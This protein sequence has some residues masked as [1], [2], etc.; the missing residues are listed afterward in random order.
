MEFIREKILGFLRILVWYFDYL[1]YL[2]FNPFKFR[3]L[4]KNIKKILVIELKYI[5]DAI[6]ITP[7]I[8]AL[9]ETY[10]GSEIDVIVPKVMTDLFKNNP[11]INEIVTFDNKSFYEKL[12]IIKDKYDLAVIFHNGTFL[13][14]FLLL[15][16]NVKF[17]I[18][19]TKVGITESKGYFLHRNTR[20]TFILKHKVDDNLDVIKT[21]NIIPKEKR[22][23]LYA[24]KTADK[25]IN[26]LLKKNKVSKKDFLVAIHPAPQ[27][28]S[29]EWFQD[30]FAELADALIKSHKAKIIFTGAKKDIEYNKEILGLMKNKAVNFAGTSLLEFISLIN[31][32][33][34]VISVDTGAMHIAAGLNKPVISLFGAGNPKIW[35]PYCK[36]SIVIFKENIAHTSCMKH[37]CYLKGNKYM[38]CMKA[39]TINDVS[40]SVQEIYKHSKSL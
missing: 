34:L 21:I 20:P 36:N 16:A 33:R 19:C 6:V 28:K 2:I 11:D 13:V 17:R 15:L 3:S 30:R 31:A 24:D 5:G 23:H 12:K 18:G 22:L 39:I 27:H 4:P 7:A 26:D 14:S 8:H 38:E 40:K 29:H 35:K 9:K 10:K 25:K 1:I 37:S 32:S